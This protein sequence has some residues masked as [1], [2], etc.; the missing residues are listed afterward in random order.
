[1][2]VN[3]I[4][5]LLASK[6]IVLVFVEFW[7]LVDGPVMSF[8]GAIFCPQVSQICCDKSPPLFGKDIPIS[9]F[10]FSLQVGDGRDGLGSR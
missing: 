8:V 2:C 1:M 5:S 4:M 3:K 9:K 10:S 6:C 7:S